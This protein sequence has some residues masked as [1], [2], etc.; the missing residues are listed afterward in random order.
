MEASV[1]VTIIVALI[2]AVIGPAVL[3]YIKSYLKRKESD[4]DPIYEE[5]ESDILIN[6]QIQYLLDELDCDRVWVMQFH[7]GGH[8]YA[9]GISIKKFSFFYEVVGAGIA[10]VRDKFQNVPTSFFSRA[11]KEFADNDELNVD[12]MHDESKPAYGLRDTAESTGCQSLYVC[13]LKTPSGK[14]HGAIGVEFVKE[15]KGFTEDQKD[16]IRDGANYVSGIL[17][18]IHKF[19]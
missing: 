14:L 6:E 17:R 7:N 19:K 16:L 9:S 12:N 13:S 1:I 18:L 2:T 11:I 3:E 15:P 8:F 4:E 5:M 10:P